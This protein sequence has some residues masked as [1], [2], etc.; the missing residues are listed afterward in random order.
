M[1]IPLNEES[2][3]LKPETQ[4]TTASERSLFH[5]HNAFGYRGSLKDNRTRNS[6][7]IDGTQLLD[8]EK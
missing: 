5:L 7:R 3:I 6:N 8:L 1:S 4:S 2:T